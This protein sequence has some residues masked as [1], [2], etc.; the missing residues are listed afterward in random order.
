MFSNLEKPAAERSWHAALANS[1]QPQWL[2]RERDS[3]CQPPFAV[4]HINRKF[5]FTSDKEALSKYSPEYDYY[6]PLPPIPKQQDEASIAFQE[7]VNKKCEGV[8]MIPDPTVKES[9]VGNVT[10]DVF[11][12]IYNLGRAKAKQ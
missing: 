2:K 9:R 6:L 5:I 10:E 3:E 8:T 11:T 4:I 1:P 12:E 7:W